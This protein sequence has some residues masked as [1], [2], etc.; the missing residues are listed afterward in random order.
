M[1]LRSQV[2]FW[3]VMQLKTR[4]SGKQ[5]AVSLG[6]SQQQAVARL[7]QRLRPQRR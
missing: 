4:L 7:Q 2:G 6:A 3:H 5:L 1:A